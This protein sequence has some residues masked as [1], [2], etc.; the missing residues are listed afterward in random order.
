MQFLSTTES[1]IYKINYYFYANPCVVDIKE[2]LITGK[3][4]VDFP[5]SVTKRKRFD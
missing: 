5:I 3:I 4:A 2:R 1:N